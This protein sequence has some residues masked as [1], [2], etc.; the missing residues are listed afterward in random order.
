MALKLFVW[1][2]LT[3]IPGAVISGGL[4]FLAVR[5]LKFARRPTVLS[6]VEPAMAELRRLLAELDRRL[7]QFKLERETHE[8]LHQFAERLRAAASSRPNLRD[9]AE[10]YLRYAAMRYGL[11]S[12][13]PE[14]QDVLRT[15]LQ[16]VCAR[17]SGRRE[18]R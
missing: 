8:T 7:R 1:S 11:L 4:L 14:L 10:W 9:A 3:T 12:Y 2:F 5:K 13:P 18:A 6:S 17:L 15:E 16:T